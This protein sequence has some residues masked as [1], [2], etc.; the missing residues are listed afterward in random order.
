MDS[1][2]ETDLW[3]VA[4]QGIGWMFADV[5]YSHR[6]ELPTEGTSQVRRVC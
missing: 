3:T 6:I 2:L 5:P 1:W 4:V